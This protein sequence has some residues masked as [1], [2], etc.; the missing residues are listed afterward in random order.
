M[1]N[2]FADKAGLPGM[3]SFMPDLSAAAPGGGEDDLTT[4]RDQV[5][6][7]QKRLERLANKP[8]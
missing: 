3:A 6:E 7:M 4:L 1:F 5:A 8:A 2:P